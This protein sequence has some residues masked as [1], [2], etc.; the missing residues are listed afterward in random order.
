MLNRAFIDRLRDEQVNILSHEQ[1]LEFLAESF[2]YVLP[3]VAGSVC[4]GEILVDAHGNGTFQERI[5]AV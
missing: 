2:E 5:P 4:R 3:G 1:L